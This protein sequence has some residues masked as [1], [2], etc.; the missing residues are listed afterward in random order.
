MSEACLFRR[1]GFIEPRCKPL[2]LHWIQLDLAEAA[3]CQ[4]NCTKILVQQ[5]NLLFS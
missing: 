1:E 5:T 4:S 3:T 2:E